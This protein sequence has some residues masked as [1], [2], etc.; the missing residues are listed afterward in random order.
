ML[1][2]IALTGICV[3]LIAALV[4][5]GMSKTQKGALI[6]AGSGAVVGGLVGN[7]AGNTAVGAIIGAAVGGA[8]GAYIGHYMDQQAEEMQKDLEGARIERVGEGIKITFAS[9]IL[10]DVNKADLRPEAQQ[11]LVN[12]A[13][14]LNKYAE[15]NV[16]IEGHTDTTGSDSYNLT[17]SRSRAE[18]VSSFL[19]AQ[20][21]VSNR[22][23]IQGY[24]E[25]Q[26]IATENT[27]A[28]MQ[29]NRR[30][31]IAIYANDKLKKAAEEQV[32]EG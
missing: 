5:C 4:G 31:E 24:G 19:A 26:P 8:A 1:R 2:H 21:V 20:Q 3:V 23:I 10:F 30:V 13:A 15:T 11:N 9:G 16:L 28:A 22:F 14:I 12:L 27:A 6:G 29:A 17:L 7:A 18:S 25:Q 32:Q